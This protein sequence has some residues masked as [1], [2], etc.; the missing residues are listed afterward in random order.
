MNFA[1][2]F[3][4]DVIGLDKIFFELPLGSCSF[5]WVFLELVESGGA[6]WPDVVKSIGLYALFLVAIEGIGQRTRLLHNY[7]SYFLLSKEL[8]L[9]GCV[10]FWLKLR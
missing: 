2:L 8:E 4:K 1:P 5:F 7:L 10:L 9:A 6:A 3:V